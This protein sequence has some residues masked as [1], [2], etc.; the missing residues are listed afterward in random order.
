MISALKP[1]AQSVARLLLIG[2][3]SLTK[4]KSVS[5]LVSETLA[6]SHEK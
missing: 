2:E 5:F 4:V 1:G 6:L 3:P